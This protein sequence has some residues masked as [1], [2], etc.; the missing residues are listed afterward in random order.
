MTLKQGVHA[1]N[2][3]VH[4]KLKML[5]YLCNPTLLEPQ[6]DIKMYAYMYFVM[7]HGFALYVHFWEKTLK[8]HKMI[9]PENHIF[10]FRVQIRNILSRM[11]RI[12]AF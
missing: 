4:R 3:V 12:Q 10:I 8:S 11:Y 1:P 7:I 6:H 2:P 9:S 5:F